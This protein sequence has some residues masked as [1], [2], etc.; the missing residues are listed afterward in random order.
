MQDVISTYQIKPPYIIGF[1][2]EDQY[3]EILGEDTLTADIK[4]ELG[5]KKIKKP[6]IEKLIEKLRAEHAQVSFY[7]NA[8]RGKLESVEQFVSAAKR[9][10]PEKRTTIAERLRQRQEEGTA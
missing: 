7:K 8:F 3:K 2:D 5:I 1:A 6:S 4:E 9:L 10:S